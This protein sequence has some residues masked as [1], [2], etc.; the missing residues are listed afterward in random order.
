M[1]CRSGRRHLMSDS[2]NP[3]SAHPSG[4]NSF[5]RSC[6]TGYRSR[7]A[8]D[9]ASASS[10]AAQAMSIA[11]GPRS[12]QPHVC[13]GLNCRDRQ[14]PHKG[15]V[16]K[17]PLG[18]LLPGFN[19]PFPAEDLEDVAERHATGPS[20]AQF[21]PWNRHANVICRI[22][23]PEKPYRTIGNRVVLAPLQLTGTP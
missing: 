23:Y 16:N 18:V 2:A 6:S 15:Q 22:V 3:H 9:A 13:I 11:A 10:N 20:Q 19:T 1:A 21:G 14:S 17:R 5:R 4:T 12:A 8:K 7:R